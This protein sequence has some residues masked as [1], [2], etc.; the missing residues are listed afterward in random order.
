MSLSLRTARRGPRSAWDWF[1]WAIWGALIV[2]IAVNAGM[3][4]AALATFPGSAGPDGFD[5]SNDYNRVLRAE[6]QEK[7]LGWH[8][9]LRLSGGNVLR[10][11]LTGPG[12]AVLAGAAPAAV[13]ERPVGPKERRAI[14]FRAVAP[15]RFL[16]TQG[17]PRG[18]WDVLLTVR[19]A[20]HVFTTAE[21]IVAEE[22]R[23]P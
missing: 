19:A 12:G 10:L 14:V 6:A 9:A 20:G 22:R 17:L 18:R 11:D 4:W 13:A 23:V 1:P 3:I 16:A 15:G 2:V 7:A 5:L 21:R 8:V